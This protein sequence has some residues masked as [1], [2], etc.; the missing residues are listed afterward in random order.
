LCAQN[1]F[2][3]RDSLSTHEELKI[4]LHSTHSRQALLL[5]L[6]IRPVDEE[7]MRLAGKDCVMG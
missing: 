7:M 4:T 3:E 1:C 6:L 5:R 2:S